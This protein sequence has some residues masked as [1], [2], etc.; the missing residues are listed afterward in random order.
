MDLVAKDVVKAF[1]IYMTS[2]PIGSLVQLSNDCV[3]KVV[4]T[5]PGAI[6]KP[7]VTVLTDH[8]GTILPVK[9][10]YQINT[11]EDYSITIVKALSPYHLPS[12]GI[13]D[14]FFS[15]SN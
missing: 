3:A 15:A 11:A 2:Y 13:M 9:R 12:V 10:M 1:I 4:D 7:V 5:A 6:S 8:E 14:G